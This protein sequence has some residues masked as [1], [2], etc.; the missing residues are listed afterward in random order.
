MTEIGKLI[1]LRNRFLALA[2]F[3]FLLW[4]GMQMAETLIAPDAPTALRGALIG[5]GL[6]GIFGFIASMLIFLTY[7]RRV[8]SSRTQDVIQ[9]E[10]FAF[11]QARSIRIAYIALM[12]TIALA[13]VL[14]EFVVLD[15]DLLARGLMV[16]G[17][18]VPP[19]TFIWLDS[20]TGPE[21]EV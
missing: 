6:A 11:N 9:D 16:I 12:A 17:V 19:L 7:A 15:A 18:C 8:T 2:A 4:H 5:L 13:Y 1:R 10:F 21:D 3:S 14:S 20:R